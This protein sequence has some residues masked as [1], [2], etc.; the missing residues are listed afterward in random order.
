[1]PWRYDSEMGTTNLLHA[2]A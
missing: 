2:S 1:M